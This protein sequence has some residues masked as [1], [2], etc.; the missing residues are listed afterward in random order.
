VSVNNSRIV[1]IQEN[2]AIVDIDITY[3]KGSQT[4][5]ERLRMNLVWN[6]ALGQWQIN[7]TSKP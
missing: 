3:Q 5:P 1:A 2:N 7:E 4:F 6:E